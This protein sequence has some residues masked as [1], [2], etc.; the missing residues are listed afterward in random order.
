[1]VEIS[2]FHPPGPSS[3]PCEIKQGLG[4]RVSDQSTLIFPTSNQM[5]KKV[6]PHTLSSA[7]ICTCSLQQILD[8]D[9]P[10]FHTLD[11]TLL[12]LTP[13]WT[14]EVV[15][16]LTGVRPRMVAVLELAGV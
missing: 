14:V 3:F 10:I 15:V 8:E 6:D 16:R 12:N 1:M 5:T 7:C 11:P 4:L 9:L 13:T 2:E